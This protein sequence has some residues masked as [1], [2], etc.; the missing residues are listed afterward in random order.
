MAKHYCYIP[1][2]DLELIIKEALLFNY[3]GSNREWT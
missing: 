2:S 3:N 1:S